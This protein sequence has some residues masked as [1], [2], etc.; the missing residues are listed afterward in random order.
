MLC[1]INDRPS[2]EKTKSDPWHSVSKEK[3]SD[4]I[5]HFFFG[6]VDIA[7]HPGVWVVEWGLD[8]G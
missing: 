3:G 8:A 1:S 7:Y 5:I 4:Q 6:E 2:R